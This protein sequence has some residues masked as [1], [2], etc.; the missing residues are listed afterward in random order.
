MRNESDNFTLG[1]DSGKP[2]VII[3][4]SC[5]ETTLPPQS[6]V[7]ARLRSHQAMQIDYPVSI[8][9]GFSR[10]GRGKQICRTEV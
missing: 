3:V 4:L 1:I 6:S 5:N 9:P 7:Q 2:E 8:F 10:A